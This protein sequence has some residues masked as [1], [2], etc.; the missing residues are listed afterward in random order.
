MDRF[1]YYQFLLD[2]MD[3]KAMTSDDIDDLYILIDGLDDYRAFVLFGNYQ[4]MEADILGDPKALIDKIQK[5]HDQKRL[6]K[7]YLIKFNNSG[8][9]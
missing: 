2:L 6:Q 5:I 9:I 3:N 8:R 1:N 4:D 7:K